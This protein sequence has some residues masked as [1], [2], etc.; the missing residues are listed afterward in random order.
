MHLLDIAAKD[1]AG[2]LVN[3]AHYF[4][5]DDYAY[6]TLAAHAIT[7]ALA[8]DVYELSAKAKDCLVYDSQETMKFSLVDEQTQSNNNPLSRSGHGSSL[9]Y[10]NS[11]TIDVRK[12]SKNL[13]FF[14]TRVLEDGRVVRICHDEDTTAAI[15][16]RIYEKARAL[17]SSAVESANA[18]IDAL[19]SSISNEEQLAKQTEYCE[20]WR[21]ALSSA[22]EYATDV[23][24]QISY[25]KQYIAFSV[26]HNKNSNKPIYDPQYGYGSE[27]K[28]P[29]PKRM[30]IVA[31]SNWADVLQA[32]L[33]A[34]NANPNADRLA[35]LNARMGKASFLSE[36]ESIAL[37]DAPKIELFTYVLD[38]RTAKT[39][40][41][42]VTV[43]YLV[44]MES[45]LSDINKVLGADDAVKNILRQLSPEQTAAIKREVSRL[46]RMTL[47]KSTGVHAEQNAINHASALATVDDS[48]AAAVRRAADRV[49]HAV[50]IVLMQELIAC[51]HAQTMLAQRVGAAGQVMAGASW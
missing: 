39:G 24:E 36:G 19:L 23:D 17:V 34:T 22:L 20:R 42:A 15:I 44:N 21:D 9:S 41:H 13:L 16:T 14:S 8:N 40:D 47:H 49:Q 50:N 26:M 18:T 33:P 29:E 25:I 30:L 1:A 28:D 3:S 51:R 7:S 37:G 5:G 4:T 11:I 2:N 10:A 46:D 48:Y 38:F 27:K 45:S 32:L 6:K 43:D 12:L 31:G 35:S